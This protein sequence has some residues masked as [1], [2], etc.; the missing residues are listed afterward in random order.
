[1]DAAVS[2]A[3][4]AVLILW[5]GYVIA[6]GGA[7]LFYFHDEWGRMGDVPGSFPGARLVR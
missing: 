1:M 5:D 7:W 4:D 6:D 2:I 3:V